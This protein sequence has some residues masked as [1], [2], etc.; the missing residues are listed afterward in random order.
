MAKTRHLKSVR[1]RLSEEDAALCVE[2]LR[3]GGVVVFPTDTVYGIGCN[4]FNPVS[5]ARVYELKG[6][7]YAKPLPIFMAEVRQLSLVAD[8][9]PKEAQ[10]LME[11]F[12]PGAL[13]L[14]FKTARLALHASRGKSTIAV[15]IPDH[16]VARQLLDA[17]YL[18]LAVTSAYLSGENAPKTAA[19]VKKI[20][21]GRVDIIVDGN[22]PGG[23]E[24][25][26]VDASH[27]PFTVLREGAI[28]KQELMRGLER[29]KRP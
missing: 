25:S 11:S 13:T 10:R 5:I 6:R 24:S 3:A 27:F 12:W 16:G 26:V 17:L 18:P 29:G 9:I 15:R 2:V 28:P 19:A 23:R 22:C 21:E 8:E 1:G 7:D 20:F 4:A 14:V